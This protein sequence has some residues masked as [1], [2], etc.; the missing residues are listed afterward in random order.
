MR[1]KISH[2]KSRSTFVSVHT[3]LLHRLRYPLNSV[4]PVR[5]LGIGYRHGGQNGACTPFRFRGG[6]RGRL[7]PC[8]SVRLG[9]A[10]RWAAAHRP[11]ACPQPSLSL[12]SFAR[13]ELRVAGRVVFARKPSKI[14]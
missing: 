4:G 1:S 7:C 12:T 13:R 10:D 6:E 8:F 11:L 14:G 3:T 5:L 9:R 2:Y